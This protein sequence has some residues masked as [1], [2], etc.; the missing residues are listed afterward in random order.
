VSNQAVIYWYCYRTPGLKEPQ[1]LKHLKA[2][3]AARWQKT[4]YILFFAQLMTAVGFSSIFPF[5]P[6]YVQEL[7][8]VSGLSIELLSGL[9]FSGQ[10]FTMMLAAP[11]WGSLADRYG[12]KIMVERALF[13]GAILLFLMAFARSAEELVILRALQG[14]VTGTVAAANAL[15]AAQAPRERAGYAMG[16][17]TV[18]M[19][20]GVA[21]GPLI[22]GVIA[23]VF[24]Y[25][26]AFY[27]PAVLLLLAG[28]IVLFGIQETFVR[29]QEQP[30]RRPSILRSWWSILTAQG[31]GVAYSMRFIA[32]L[33]GNMILP[34]APLFIQSLMTETTSVNTTTGMVVGV[35]S[36]TTTASAIY[37][38]RLGDRIGHRRIIIVCAVAAGV[39]YTIQWRVTAPW[40]LLVLQALVGV[41]VGGIVPSISALLARFSHPG[42]EG[43]VFGLD[44]SITS[45]ARSVAPMIGAAVAHAVA[46]RTTF[47]AAA[48]LY[49]AL[50]LLASRKLPSTEQ[51]VS[52]TEVRVRAE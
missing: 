18:S 49:L 39:L 35:S 12:R 44:N 7:G 34:I 2:L 28:F 23:D 41:A 29:P 4:L 21:L 31:V 11:I 10:A 50:A 32:Q 40:Q 47:L 42:E 14:L 38:G 48:V 27:V 26:A 8:A 9:V 43:A 24:S 30:G 5:L 17:L 52:F 15:V 16:L 1:S 19:G 45:G 20:A 13:G 37:M 25:S 22:G 6:L 46:L 33:A 3:L 51:V 36:A